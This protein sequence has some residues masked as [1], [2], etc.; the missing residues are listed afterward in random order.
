MLSYKPGSPSGPAG[1]CGISIGGR[2][3]SD[4]LP[5]ALL[6]QRRDLPHRIIL[7]LYK[8]ISTSIVVWNTMGKILKK[9]MQTKH[10]RGQT[11][12][13]AQCKALFFCLFVFLFFFCLFFV[14]FPPFCPSISHQ[15]NEKG[16]GRYRRRRE[17]KKREKKEEKR[18]KERG[19]REEGK[20][21]KILLFFFFFFFYKCCVVYFKRMP[22]ILS[23]TTNEQP[24]R[25][26]QDT[27][28]QI[29]SCKLV[30]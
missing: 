18:K 22:I 5:Q 6:H 3:C 20:I 28:K 21:C 1:L 7:H 8:A 30:I 4:S 9:L 23:A 11:G 13:Q 24:R 12:G 10:S 15:K 14:F 26:F 27:T 25:H 17:R 19:G 29:Y 2:A 16:S